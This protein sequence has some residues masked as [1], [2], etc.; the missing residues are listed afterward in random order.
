MMQAAT[1]NPAATTAAAAA[2]PTILKAHQLM[3]SGYIRGCNLALA[4]PHRLKRDS[5]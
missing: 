1:E 4:A 2:S 3:L 5:L